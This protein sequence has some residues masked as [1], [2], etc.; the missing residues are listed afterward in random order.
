MCSWS[1]RKGC[2]YFPWSCWPYNI[3]LLHVLQ[4]PDVFTFRERDGHTRLYFLGVPSGKRQNTLM[5]CDIDENGGAPEWKQLL[6]TEETTNGE[7]TL[8]KV[9]FCAYW[10]AVSRFLSSASLRMPND[11]DFILWCNYLHL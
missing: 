7:T 3:I 4:V 2:F 9:C 10:S 8:T 11:H 1:T 5:Y 6:D